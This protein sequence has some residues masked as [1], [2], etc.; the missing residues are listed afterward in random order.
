[1][2]YVYFNSSIRYLHNAALID[3]LLWTKTVP[4]DCPAVRKSYL[5]LLGRQLQAAVIHRTNFIFHM[6]GGAD[7]GSEQ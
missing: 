7:D 1:M 2:L 6:A 4:M 5:L 3:L